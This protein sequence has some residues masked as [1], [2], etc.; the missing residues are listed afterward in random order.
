MEHRTAQEPLKNGSSVRV[1][2]LV[3]PADALL[4]TY[5]RGEGW[6]LLGWVAAPRLGR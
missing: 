1:G 4:E 6:G 3:A 2:D 5:G